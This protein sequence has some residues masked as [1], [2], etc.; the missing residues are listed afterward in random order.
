LRADETSSTLS[1]LKRC[2]SGK[3]SLTDAKKLS[4]PT[5]TFIEKMA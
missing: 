1:Q 4:F 5:V 3:I 2:D